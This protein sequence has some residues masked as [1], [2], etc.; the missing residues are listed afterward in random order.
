MWEIFQKRF[1]EAKNKLTFMTNLL[2]LQMH[3]SGI[4][5][6]YFQKNF[7]D[8]LNEVNKNKG[9]EGV[10]RVTWDHQEQQ[11]SGIL[12]NWDRF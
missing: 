7:K 6:R 11:L 8:T 5:K 12:Q 9:D 4:F 2:P 1:L 10:I 3:L